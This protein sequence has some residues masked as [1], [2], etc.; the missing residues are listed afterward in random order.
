[1]VHALLFDLDDTLYEERQFFYSGFR[2]MAAIL[3]Q[4]GFGPADETV[5]ALDYLHH[6][7]GREGVLQKL[8][9]RLGFAP[10]LIPELVEAF[11]THEPDI[12]LARDA[13]EV[14]PRLAGRYRIGCVTDGWARVQR[15][16]LQ[17]LGVGM[18]L[19]AVVIADDFG[20]D[21]WKPDPFPFRRCCELLGVAEADAVFVGDYPDRDML[22]AHNAG[23][24][25]V[26][27]RRPGAYFASVDASTPELAPLFDVRDLFELETRLDEL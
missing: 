23:L 16:K 27:I 13:V 7:E 10:E 11:R 5:R 15:S 3:E 1:M 9:V 18:Y 26:R 12:K 24:R 17:A 4:Q 21:R 8:S 6:Q 20:R 22:G 14:L 2:V 19:H 25:C